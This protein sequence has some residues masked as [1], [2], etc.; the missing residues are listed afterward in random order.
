ME[1]KKEKGFTLIELLVVISIIGM[2]SSVVLAT[3]NTARDKA[4]VAAAQKFSGYNS[5]TLGADAAG[6]WNFDEGSG[7]IAYDVSGNGNNA[8][9]SVGATR[10]TETPNKVGGAI[11]LAAGTYAGVPYSQSID[12]SKGTLSAWIKT[13]NSAIQ[14]VVVKVGS[15]SFYIRTGL[16]VLYDSAANLY[17]GTNTYVSDDKW[18]HV[19][20]SFNHNVANGLNIYIDGQLKYTGTASTPSGGLNGLGIGS[21]FYNSAATT[22]TGYIDEVAIYNEVL[23]QDKIK[24]IYAK[25]SI[26]Y[27]LAIK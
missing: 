1:N 18:H 4:R 9:L 26:K 25:G 6:I 17:K 5:R 3:V 19:A 23:A 10:V 8:T 20:I 22:F 27:G 15:Y 16:A 11:Y 7:L 24:E 13:S 2:M 12:R 14:A 21:A